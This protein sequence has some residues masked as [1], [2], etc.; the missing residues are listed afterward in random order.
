MMENLSNGSLKIKA[1]MQQLQTYVRDGLQNFKTIFELSSKQQ[2]LARCVTNKMKIFIKLELNYSTVAQCW[3]IQKLSKWVQHKI[4][5]WNISQQLNTWTEKNP[6]W[7]MK[8]VCTSRTKFVLRS[9]T[10]I[11]ISIYAEST[12]EKV[13]SFSEI[14]AEFFIMNSWNQDNLLL[15]Q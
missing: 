7:T 15:H 5:E 1:I 3:K 9:M 8:A 10:A 14:Q 13:L 12:G 2:V 6:F 11:N 4:K